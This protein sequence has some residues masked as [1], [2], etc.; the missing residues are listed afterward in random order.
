MS[1]YKILVK[2]SKERSVMFSA[3]E[4][5]LYKGYSYFFCKLANI[6]TEAGCDGCPANTECFAFSSEK[7]PYVTENEMKKF[8]LN[9]PEH[10]L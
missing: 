9:F 2:Y 5:D 10:C 3:N 7:W 1:H 4:D 8:K 6:N